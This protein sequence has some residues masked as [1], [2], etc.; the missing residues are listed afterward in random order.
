VRKEN[1]IQWV[2][3]P[4]ANLIT[5]SW[6]RSIEGVKTR[7][8]LYS[9]EG[10]VLAQQSDAELEKKIGVFQD[11]DTPDETLTTAQITALAK[12]MLLQ[13]KAA[14]NTLSVEVLGNAEVI[15]GIGV[16]IIIPQ[17]G[18]SQT[19]YVDEDTHTFEDNKHT[20]TLK[21]NIASDIGV[22][23]G[24]KS[25]EIKKGDIVYFSGGV[26]Y[27]ASTDKTSK[28]GTRTAGK[29]WVQNIAPNA[30]H[31]YALIGGAYRSDVGGNSNVYGW[32]DES[33]VSSI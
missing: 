5:Y 10:V 11:V 29:A 25:Q 15:S 28:G 14:E 19:Y 17:L 13:E 31:K 26:H 23:E 16:Y 3:E 8:K 7:I 20:M 1:V 12:S 33:T 2:I 32:V 6:T 30:P 18:I 24:E 22:Q 21:L 27:T 4:T 9:D